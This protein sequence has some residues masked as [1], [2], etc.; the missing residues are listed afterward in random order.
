MCV[1]AVCAD[2]VDV[3]RHGARRGEVVLV[4]ALRVSDEVAG[5]ASRAAT[6]GDKPAAA[7]DPRRVDIV[8]VIAVRVGE[9]GMV[10]IDV[11][12][13]SRPAVAVIALRVGGVIVR[14][15]IDRGAAVR[16]VALHVGRQRIV[17]QMRLGDDVPHVAEVLGA[18][19]ERARAPSRVGDGA[20]ADRCSP[21][22]VG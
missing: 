7:I 22:R 4:G 8:R 16:V 11:V 9:T 2:P 19:R 14:A 17:G 5:I 10:V 20:G 6:A 21:V 12:A 18:E 15:G 13:A 3:V 1:V